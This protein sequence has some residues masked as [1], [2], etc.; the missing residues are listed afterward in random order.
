MDITPI[1]K[2]IDEHDLTSK[3]KLSKGEIIPV[4][5]HT[6]IWEIG[7]GQTY[8]TAA[9][10]ALSNLAGEAESKHLKTGGDFEL[11][12]P[13][14]ELE[15]AITEAY[16]NRKPEP[17]RSAEYPAILEEFASKHGLPIFLELPGETV[18]RILIEEIKRNYTDD[19]A[20]EAAH[21]ALYRLMRESQK[22]NDLDQGHYTWL[23]K[24]AKELAETFSMPRLKRPPRLTTAQETILESFLQ[25]RKIGEKLN[26]PIEEI[27]PLFI[28][29]VEDELALKNPL[30]VAARHTISLLEAL[31]QSAHP[32]LSNLQPELEKTIQ[33]TISAR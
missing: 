9:D 14:Q 31:S 2:F 29:C 7:F 4:L 19:D 30:P 12:F 16:G 5:L 33:K 10:R 13:W 27:I 28:W 1:L 18:N 15:E 25:N 3:L 26:L 32:N 20:L 11:V 24:L 23:L 21:E 22:N 8:G 6:I 17:P